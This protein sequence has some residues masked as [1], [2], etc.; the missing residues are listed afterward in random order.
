MYVFSQEERKLIRQWKVNAF[1]NN[2]LEY[3]EAVILCGTDTANSPDIVVCRPNGYMTE[4]N[5]GVCDVAAIAES[6]QE[7]TEQLN[8]SVSK[9]HAGLPFGLRLICTEAELRLSILNKESRE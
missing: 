5:D 6:L 9:T 8:A 1:K 7:M 4:E 3:L 2:A